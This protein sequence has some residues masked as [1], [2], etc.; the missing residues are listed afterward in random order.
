[1]LIEGGGD[2]ERADWLLKRAQKLDERAALPLVE[3]A[4]IAVVR[5]AWA[6]AEGL[7][8]KAVRIEP[9][10]HAAFFVRGELCEAQGHVFPALSEFQRA[11]ERSPKESAAR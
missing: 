3:R 1:L 7:L 6:D 4:H 10:C 8:D 11:L 2:L 5:Q 9:A